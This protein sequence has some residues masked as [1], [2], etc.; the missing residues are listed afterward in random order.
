MNGTSIDS[1]SLFGTNCDETQFLTTAGGSQ[2]KAELPITVTL[3][4]AL[5]KIGAERTEYLLLLIMAVLYSVRQPAT[6]S[7]FSPVPINGLSAIGV[8]RKTNSA[9]HLRYIR[10]SNSAR[11]WE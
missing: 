4:V 9:F 8:H 11:T 3:E 2:S 7:T 5:L 6:V 10:H 1:M